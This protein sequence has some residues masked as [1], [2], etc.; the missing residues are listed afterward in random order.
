M[1][2]PTGNE[3]R[4]DRLWLSVH[5]KSVKGVPPELYHELCCRLSC[6]CDSGETAFQK[7]AGLPSWSYGEAGFIFDLD[8]CKLPHTLHTAPPKGRKGAQ[9]TTASSQYCS[10]MSLEVWGRTTRGELET[11]CRGD[12]NPYDASGSK[13]WTSK[14]RSITV[15]CPLLPQAPGEGAGFRRSSGGAAD[16]VG[17]RRFSNASTPDSPRSRSSPKKSPKKRA[18]FPGMD[19]IGG[20][21]SGDLSSPQSG[22]PPVKSVIVAC[23]LH[24][25]CPEAFASL[26][27]EVRRRGL[28]RVRHSAMHESQS[29]NE[30]ASGGAASP[31]ATPLGFAPGVGAL[32][33]A[34]PGGIPPDLGGL[35]LR[36]SIQSPLTEGAGGSSVASAAALGGHELRPN[37]T[38]FEIAR[39]NHAVLSKV[40]D[41]IGEFTSSTTKASQDIAALHQSFEELQGIVEETQNATDEMGS[42]LQRRITE[43]HGEVV[44]IQRRQKVLE[45]QKDSMGSDMAKILQKLSALELGAKKVQD[46][47][48]QQTKRGEQESASLHNEVRGISRQLDETDKRTLSVASKIDFV[49]GEVNKQSKKPEHEQS[50]AEAYLPVAISYIIKGVYAPLFLIFESLRSLSTVSYILVLLG[51]A[52]ELRPDKTDPSS[53]RGGGDAVSADAGGDAGAASLHVEEGGGRRP[54]GDGHD[55]RR[56][57]SHHRARSSEGLAE[58]TDSDDNASQITG[59]SAV[60]QNLLDSLDTHSG[61]RISRGRAST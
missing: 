51:I 11:L 26:G 48:T 5:I 15:S 56:M 61:L 13:I 58:H 3:R 18:R 28:N 4:C 29:F 49:E 57:G 45:G 34:P 55:D 1:H 36:D 10:P 20:L 40:Q 2:S 50:R 31:N 30:G 7:T 16:G 9:H 42:E 53:D 33:A 41:W 25:M 38:A 24:I 19:L 22:F 21:V 32:A 12:L 60:R 27:G 43:L 46:V 14:P 52:A 39:A 59:R 44:S 37:A 54:G 23:E 6:G 17:G 47:I 8:N 35:Q